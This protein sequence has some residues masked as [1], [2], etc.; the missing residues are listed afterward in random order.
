MELIDPKNNSVDNDVVSSNFEH[1]K[2]NP[3]ETVAK[4]VE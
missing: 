1:Y 2:K 3:E 4:N